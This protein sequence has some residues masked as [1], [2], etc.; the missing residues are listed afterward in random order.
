MALPPALDVA[1]VAV[2]ALSGALL[3]AQMRQTF[4]TMGFFALVTGVGGGSVRDVLLGVPAFWLHDPWI[5]PVILGVALVAWFTPHRW[6]EGQLLEWLDAVGL[7]VFSVLGTAKALS[8]GATPVPAAILGIV[9]G[10]VGGIIRDVLAGL[11]SILL[12]PE[13]YV[14][15]AALS[16]F[17]CAAG[18]ALNLNSPLVWSIAALA[19]FGLRGAA[20]RWGLYLPTYSRGGT[21]PPGAS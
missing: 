18:L 1:G 6:W 14:T 17:I 16:A 21:Q 8:L 2:F 3:A 7:A 9:T 19:G 5:A 13:L 12:R 4:V 11:P 10:C 20:L 15:A